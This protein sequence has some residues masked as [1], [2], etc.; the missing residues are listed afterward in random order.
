MGEERTMC[1]VAEAIKK[2]D[3]KQLKELLK[4]NTEPQ[5][6]GE[7]SPLIIAIEENNFEAVK[8]ILELG[9]NPNYEMLRGFLEGAGSF[10]T[11]IIN[12]IRMENENILQL[13]LE[14]G[15]DLFYIDDMTK[16]IPIDYVIKSKNKKIKNTIVSRLEKEISSKKEL[17]IMLV[18]AAIKLGINEDLIKTKITENLLN[19]PTINNMGAENITGLEFALERE[20]FELA[21]KLI[22][23]GADTKH[24]GSKYSKKES[25]RI[26]EFLVKKGLK[27]DYEK[28][29]MSEEWD[30]IY[31]NPIKKTPYQEEPIL[32]AVSDKDYKAVRLLCRNGADLNCEKPFSSIEAGGYVFEALTPLNIAIKNKDVKMIKMLIEL[33]ANPYYRDYKNY[34]PYDYALQSGNKDVIDIFIT[35]LNE[36]IENKKILPLQPIIAIATLSKNIDKTLK[37]KISQSLSGIPEKEKQAELKRALEE[38]NFDLAEK[39]IECGIRPS[40]KLVTLYTENKDEKILNF[41]QHRIKQKVYG[42]PRVIMVRKEKKENSKQITEIT[43]PTRL[44]KR[45]TSTKEKTALPLIYQRF[46]AIQKATTDLEKER[47]SV[48][49]RC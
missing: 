31:S 17:P 30:G 6:D 45:Q 39:L 2:Q 22:S 19:A 3:L 32:L 27:E 11:P 24:I 1:R 23:L 38:G 18:I 35:F 21:E 37:Y 44:K 29:T 26:V 43:T 49:V 34:S 12:A 20:D 14:H 7:R 4:N 36:E 5:E 40:K 9:G 15:A 8:L 25:P 28:S 47:C 33:G 48:L 42:G 10:E 13:L 41:L 46:L 16:K